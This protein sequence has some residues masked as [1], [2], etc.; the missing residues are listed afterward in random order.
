MV[1]TV[2]CYDGNRFWVFSKDAGPGSRGGFWRSK[3]FVQR[4]RLR[5][6]ILGFLL[7]IFSFFFLLSVF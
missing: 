2:A 4:Q 1:K 7:F 5:R 3:A 6:F